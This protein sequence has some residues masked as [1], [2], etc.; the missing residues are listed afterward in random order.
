MMKAFVFKILIILIFSYNV[1]FSTTLY[2]CLL[3]AKTGTALI[4][5]PSVL[6]I[7]KT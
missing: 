7:I 2:L 5:A 6:I 3:K 1:H 4:L